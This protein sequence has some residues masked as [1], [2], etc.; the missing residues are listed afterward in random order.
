[1]SF[2]AGGGFRCAGVAL[3]LDEAETGAVEVVTGGTGDR[4]VTAGAIGCG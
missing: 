1:M 3:S 4:A 2:V